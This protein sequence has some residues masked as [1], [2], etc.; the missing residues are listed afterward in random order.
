M[1][2]WKF[3]LTLTKIFASSNIYWV[4][5]NPA[6]K[7]YAIDKERKEQV[8]KKERESFLFC[9]LFCQDL[10]FEGGETMRYDCMRLRNWAW[11]RWVESPRGWEHFFFFFIF[12]VLDRYSFTYR[13]TVF[14]VVLPKQSG[15]GRYLNQNE[16]TTFL[17]QQRCR[18]GKYRL[19]Q[20][21]WY[22]INSLNQEPY[23]IID[24]FWYTKCFGV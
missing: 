8:W 19:Y 20:P 9:L 14:Y 18:N 17:Y 3:L 23:S 15:M 4:S 12:L 21:V 22:E 1:K 13:N 5:W 7:L 2:L 11:R 24:T 16:T 6:S 10:Q